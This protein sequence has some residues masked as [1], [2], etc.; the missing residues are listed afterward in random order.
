MRIGSPEVACKE[1][2]FSV[3][4]S[5][6]VDAINGLEEAVSGLD[7]AFAPVLTPEPPQGAGENSKVCESPS[8]YTSSM[9]GFIARIQGATAHVRNICRRSE[10]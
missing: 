2:G 7:Q 4:S 5:R 1:R 6:M 10:I 9:S 3:Q 8:E